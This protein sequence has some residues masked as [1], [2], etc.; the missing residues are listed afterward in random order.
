[1]KSRECVNIGRGTAIPIGIIVGPSGCCWI[2]IQKKDVEKK[3]GS[4][5]QKENKKIILARRNPD[6]KP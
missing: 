3:H 2:S 5:E 1:L 6:P 4:A